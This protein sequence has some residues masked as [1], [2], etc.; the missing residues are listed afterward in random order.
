MPEEPQD[1]DEALEGRPDDLEIK[2]EEP[3]EDAEQADVPLPVGEALRPSEATRITCSVPTNVIVLG[4][5]EKGGKTTLISSL[6]ERFV[7]GPFSEY[8]F[9]GS[10]TLMGFE[11]ISHLGR[12]L[13]GRTEPDTDR[14]PL[15]SSRLMYHLRLRC[16]RESRH[17][18]LLFVDLSGEEFDDICNSS[19]ACHD[20]HV[21]RRA[22]YFIL[23]IDGR[24]LVDCALRHSVR[25][26]AF[27][28]LRRL[29]ETDVLSDRSRVDVVFSKW[30]LVESSPGKDEA[31]Q[32][33]E[34]IESEVRER[35]GISF[36][37]LRFETIKARQPD[38]GCLPATGVESLLPAWF[39]NSRPMNT[40]EHVAKPSMMPGREIDRFS[41]VSRDSRKGEH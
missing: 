36:A 23:L 29:I 6:Y 5:A 3:P 39:S 40:S 21:I 11:K 20:L 8:S 41:A 12:T 26:E 38:G 4:G 22:D 14:T 19:D 24:K 35:F 32:F 7:L 15:A 31:E 13:S 37:G 25:D 10:A 33:R 18:D 9:A 17:Q 16:Q 2:P 28:F 30:D 1:K 27:I 34:G